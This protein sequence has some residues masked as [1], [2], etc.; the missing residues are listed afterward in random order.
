MFIS[1]NKLTFN[2]INNLKMN[3]NPFPGSDI[4]IPL[5]I[6]ETVYT[7][8]HYGENLITFKPIILQFLIGYYAYGLDRFNDAKMYKKTPFI[9]RKTELYDYINNNNKNIIYNI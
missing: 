8:F 6:F 7:N 5:T 2:K 9:T 4:G 3:V 1:P